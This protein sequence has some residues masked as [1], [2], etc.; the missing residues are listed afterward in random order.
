ML[1]KF[2]LE[3]SM[4]Q[5]LLKPTRKATATLVTLKV[6]NL[7]SHARDSKTVEPLL[8]CREKMT[9]E[10]TLPSEQEQNKC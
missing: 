3:D 2:L 7:D 4:M 1:Q 5:G 8:I 9:K 10:V 6:V